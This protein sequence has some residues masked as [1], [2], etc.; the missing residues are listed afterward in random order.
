[1]TLCRWT[2]SCPFVLRPQ[3][4]HER[5]KSPRRRQGQSTRPIHK[6]RNWRKRKTKKKMMKR[7]VCNTPVAIEIQKN[8]TSS[9]CC[10]HFAACRLYSS[11]ELARTLRFVILFISD[12]W[13]PVIWNLMQDFLKIFTK[14]RRECFTV[15]LPRYE[16]A[17]S[18]SVGVPIVSTR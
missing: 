2:M 3:P 12:T 13:K 11:G 6:L 4:R 16:T 8:S 1:M 10:H 15:G 14:I 18:T 7:K 9:N 5:S 17:C